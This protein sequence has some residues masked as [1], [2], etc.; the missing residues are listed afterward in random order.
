MENL[1][2][3][4]K[5]IDY[6]EIVIT[7]IY[8]NKRIDRLLSDLIEGVSRSRLKKLI[9]SQFICLNGG[10]TEPSHITKIGEII[11]IRLPEL[12]LVNLKPQEIPLLPSISAS[13]KNFHLTPGYFSLVFHS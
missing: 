5:D 12:E 11:Q 8:A 10:R 2:I 6:F 7:K 13:T 9:D 1:D 3:E 4:Y